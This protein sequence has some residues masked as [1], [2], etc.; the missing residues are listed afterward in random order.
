MTIQ[1]AFLTPMDR[2]S[3]TSAALRLQDEALAMINLAEAVASFEDATGR[4]IAVVDAEQS[5]GP[6]T[7]NPGLWSLGAMLSTQPVPAVAGDPP[8]SIGHGSTE[9]S[10][11]D[12]VKQDAE[13]MD[14]MFP[15]PVPEVEQETPAVTEARKAA[16]QAMAAAEQVETAEMIDGYFPATPKEQ[17]IMDAADEGKPLPAGCAGISGTDPAPVASKAKKAASAQKIDPRLEDAVIHINSVPVFP[18]WNRKADLELM[19]RALDGES[20]TLIAD[21]MEFSPSYIRQRFNLLVGRKN[22]KAEP[23]FSRQDVFSALRII[24]GEAA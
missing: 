3:L 23:M 21:V 4:K 8:G 19:T 18:K 6:L 2:D 11:A 1:T 14:A 13:L 12:A 17:A 20:I 24:T 22:D 7:T 10:T 16:Q 9:C 5:R 15:Q